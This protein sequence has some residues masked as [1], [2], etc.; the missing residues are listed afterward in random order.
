M[1]PVLL[2]DDLIKER[3]TPDRAVAWIRD[4]LR[5]HAEGLLVA[6]PRATAD[7]AGYPA[8]WL[9]AATAMLLAAALM[10]TGARLLSVR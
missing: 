5:D 6:P 3:L 7:L 4:A 9:V 1:K 10:L 8:M 2:D